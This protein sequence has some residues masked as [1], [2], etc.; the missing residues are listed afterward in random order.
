MREYLFRLANNHETVLNAL[1]A[2]AELFLGNMASPYMGNTNQQQSTIAFH[3]REV[4]KQ[5][6]EKEIGRSPLKQ[7]ERDGLL[8]AIFCLAWFEVGDR[9]KTLRQT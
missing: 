9:F 8:A 3:L 4:V 2:L 5:D 7:K 1:L 6:M